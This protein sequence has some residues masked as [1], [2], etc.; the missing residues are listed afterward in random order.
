MLGELRR[1]GV[2][3]VHENSEVLD[4]TWDWEQ[5]RWEVWLQVRRA[6]HASGLAGAGTTVVTACIRVPIIGACRRLCVA[7]TAVLLTCGALQPAPCR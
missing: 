6:C 4:A 3:E 1:S 7:F 2:L 5:G